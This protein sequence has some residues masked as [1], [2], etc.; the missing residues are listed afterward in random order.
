MYFDFTTELPNNANPSA[1][2]TTDGE[3]A[4][5]TAANVTVTV[6]AAPIFTYEK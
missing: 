3:A 1:A 2:S 6:D 5:E 4:Q